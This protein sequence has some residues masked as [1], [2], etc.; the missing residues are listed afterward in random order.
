MA[1]SRSKSASESPS[2]QWVDEEFMLEYPDLY[3][4]LSEQEWED[5]KKRVT[6]TLIIACE[7]RSIKAKVCDRDGK[8]GAWVTAELFTDLLKRID[9]ALNHDD[10]DW[11]KE[12][13]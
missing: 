11:R 5:K 10:L 12:T 9:T 6:G 4:F 2:L 13:R 3:E 1:M 8:R 7:G